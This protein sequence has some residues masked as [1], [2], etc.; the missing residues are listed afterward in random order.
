MG[1][2]GGRTPLIRKKAPSLLKTKPGTSIHLQAGKTRPPRYPWW[3]EAKFNDLALSQKNLAQK[4][5]SS[6]QPEHL[7]VSKDG[8]GKF[9]ITVEGTGKPFVREPFA[10]PEFCYECAVEIEQAFEIAQVIDLWPTETMERIEEMVQ[11]ALERE[12]VV[13]VWG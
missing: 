5:R 2:G 7:S 12:R 13:R 3:L 1:D 4:T 8:S 10:T 9:W 6:G 11:V